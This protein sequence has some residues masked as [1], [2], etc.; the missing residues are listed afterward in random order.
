MKHVQP[1]KMFAAMAAVLVGL[2]ASGA[3]AQE[4]STPA[5]AVDRPDLQSYVDAIRQARDPSVAI[6]AYARAESVAPGS[7]A[8][9]NVYLNRMVEFG[10]PQM[11][12]TQAQ[13][14]V[15][16]D[17]TNGLAWGVLAYSKATRGDTKDAL[18]DIAKAVQYLPDNPFIQRTAGQLVAWYDTLAD[19]SKLPEL[20]K[21]AVAQVRK[22]LA[23]QRAYVGA[24]QAARG[25]Y[26]ERD[27]AAEAGPATAET[28][29]PP[30]APA[31]GDTYNY[32]DYGGVYPYSD[33]AL[34]PDYLPY[35]NYYRYYGGYWW[36]GPSS[37]II[38]PFDGGFLHHDHYFAHRAPDL[39][40]FA[41]FPGHR[42][43]GLHGHE[44][45]FGAPGGD[46]AR[47]LRLGPQ[48]GLNTFGLHRGFAVGPEHRGLAFRGGRST[49]GPTFR[50]PRS[51]TTP[52]LGVTPR[53]GAGPRFA[54]G[55][56]FGRR[57]A[58]APHFAPRI[59]PAPHFGGGFAAAGPHFGG[60]HFGGGHFGGGHFGG[61]HF[62]GRR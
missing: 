9:D 54:P 60:S 50:T 61:G 31:Y 32:Y 51:F 17:K 22:E 26:E 19:Q 47:G 2:A 30:I 43:F 46:H 15:K 18:T 28:I 4:P 3:A 29:P 5:V 45:P 6:D 48:G 55:L 35:P 11:A 13:K 16:R 38:V 20:V 62:G 53:F 39:D 1:L 37:T 56:H 42:A 58:P 12:D 8:L 52:R 10:L 24:Y 36:P 34:Y 27:N 25:T 21:Q 44:R 33:Y 57:V 14:L 41:H 59:A 23:D 7:D 49:L 40:D